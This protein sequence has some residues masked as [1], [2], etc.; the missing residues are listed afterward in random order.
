MLPASLTPAMPTPRQRLIAF[1]RKHGWHGRLKRETVKARGLRFAVYRTAQIA[2]ATPLVCVNGGLLFDHTLLWPALSPLAN[3]RQLILY[4]QRGRGES[5]Q[6]ADPSAAR[7]ED[8]AEDLAALRASIGLRQWD[9]LGHSWGAGIAMLGADRDVAGVRRLVLVDSLGVTSNTRDEMLSAALARLLPGER[10]LLARHTPK[11][12]STGDAG[13]HSAYTRAFFP[14]WFARREIADT[15]QLPRSTSE[16]GAAVASRLWRDGYDWS[17]LARALP[18]PT[19]VIHGE[20]DVIPLESA[21][22]LV[23]VLPRASLA[24]IPEAGHLPFIEAPDR[25]FQIVEDFLGSQ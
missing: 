23:A 1:R 24:V 9:V 18:V 10:A 15:V 6:P 17:Q 5:E 2:N 3:N 7:I 21:R 20:E 11:V 25:F 12:L 8:D 13:I 14:A 22:T 19:L 4:D 16:T